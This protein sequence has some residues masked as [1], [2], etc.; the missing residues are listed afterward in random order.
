MMAIYQY[1]QI[2]SL[3]AVT[4]V[5]PACM[6]NIPAKAL[7]INNAHANAI[8]STNVLAEKIASYADQLGDLIGSS[9]GD[10]NDKYFRHCTTQGQYDVPFKQGLVTILYLCHSWMLLATIITS[11]KGHSYKPLTKIAF[12]AFLTRCALCIFQEYQTPTID[13]KVT[14]LQPC[15][16]EMMVGALVISMRVKNSR[17]ADTEEEGATDNDSVTH[18]SHV[19]TEVIPT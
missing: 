5:M 18:P 4:S 17:Q 13:F 3:V 14:V 7:A 8:L 2:T 16:V 9:Y 15:W 6:N 10:E 19:A 1:F 12:T 11:I